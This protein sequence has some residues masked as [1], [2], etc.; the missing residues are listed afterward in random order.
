MKQNNHKNTL[1]FFVIAIFTLAFCW[2]ESLELLAGVRGDAIP[3][4][5]QIVQPPD[6]WSQTSDW[7]ELLFIYE[8]RCLWQSLIFLFP[9]VDL[10]MSEHVLPIALFCGV[11][12]QMID[13]LADHN[14][15]FGMVFLIYTMWASVTLMMFIMLCNLFITMKKNLIALTFFCFFVLISFAFIRLYHYAL[16][17]KYLDGFFYPFI[18][19]ALIGIRLCYLSKGKKRLFW[20]LFVLFCVFHC[21][22]YRR[23]A[24]LSLP[25][26]FYGLVPLLFGIKKRLY[27]LLTA[28]AC[29]F[30]FGFAS[31][32]AINLLPS[33]HKHSAVIMMY[34]DMSIAGLLS[35]DWDS[36]QTTFKENGYYGPRAVD[37]SHP[38][39]KLSQLYT[40]FRLPAPDSQEQW[41]NFL[42]TYIDYTRKYPK[43]M[44]LGKMISIMQ[45]Y[46]NFHIPR[47]I[48]RFVEKSCPNAQLEEKHWDI[49]TANLSDNGGSYEKIYLFGIA[50]AILMFL[51][52][53]HKHLDGEM[54][55]FAFVSVVGFAYSFSY[56][57]VTPT[58]DPRYHSFPVLAQCFFLSYVLARVCAYCYDRL[59]NRARARDMTA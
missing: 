51:S 30:C 39:V 6:T 20:L 8:G 54:R 4:L 34:S 7:H 40:G 57:P 35:G 10:F 15:T 22:G 56:W 37:K 46:T 11:K 55:F 45:F 49:S 41:E 36:L 47:F 5:W 24:I 52:Y 19:S 16:F 53:C 31:L 13:E 25:V 33:T 2:L 42:N 12:Q 3:I 28:S 38:N 43:E 23:V 9:N 26:I 14:I 21:M 18:I 27:R 59:R 58:P 44:F 1:I 48:K 32:Y 50:G 29:A 17:G